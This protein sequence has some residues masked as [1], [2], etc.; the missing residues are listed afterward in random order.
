MTVDAT[1]TS[2]VA[3]REPSTMA[4]MIWPAKPGLLTGWMR[5]CLLVAAGA[6]L[7]TLSAKVVVPG[8][9]NMTLQ[10][11][12]VLVLGGA[13]GARIA[14]GSVV[15]YLLEG[16]MGLPVFTGT[17][18]ALAGLAYFAGPTGGFLL[19][20]LPAAL[21]V[22]LAADRGLMRSP[23]AFA[24]ALIAADLVMLACGL[25]WLAIVASV[26]GGAFG[27]IGLTKAF[28]LGVQPFLLGECLKVALAALTLPAIWGGVHRLMSR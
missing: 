19:G 8:P 23:I 27:G 4:G 20:F 18:P 10:T 28:A 3:A 17:P 24:G 14:V 25:L 26:G 16:A 2:I 13:F 9:V 7:L 1:G 5:A 12:A 6:C 21:I 15:A 22:G 11:L